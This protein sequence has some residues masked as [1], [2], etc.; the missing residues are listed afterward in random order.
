[1]AGSAEATSADNLPACGG[2]FLFDFFICFELHLKSLSTIHVIIQPAGLSD[3]LK[4]A[5]AI[6]SEEP[7]RSSSR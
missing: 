3:I 6:F 1:M 4:K 5:V 2:A 7:H